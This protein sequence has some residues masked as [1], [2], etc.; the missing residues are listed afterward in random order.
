M[1][2]G[3]ALYALTRSLKAYTMGGEELRTQ[4]GPFDEHI[5]S[6]ARKFNIDPDL[7]RA[8]IKVESDGDPQAKAWEKLIENYSYGLM[9][10]SWPT[11]EWMGYKGDPADLLQPG[12]NIHYGSKYIAYQLDRYDNDIPS[13]AA[14]YNAGTAFRDNGKFNNQYYVNKVMKAYN[15]LKR[16]A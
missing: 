3:A 16:G 11:A 6:S 15:N 13:T 7:I 8:F 5:L 12:V 10:V 2:T 14:A 9:Q 1:V 4:L